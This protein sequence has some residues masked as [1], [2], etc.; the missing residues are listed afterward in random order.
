MHS[1]KPLWQR[2]AESDHLLFICLITVL[3]PKKKSYK[4]AS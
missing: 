1:Q 2:D 4:T 3:A